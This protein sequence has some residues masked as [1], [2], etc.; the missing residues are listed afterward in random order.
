MGQGESRSIPIGGRKI[1]R[2]RQ[3]AE[4]AYGFVDLA[5]DKRTKE[6]FALKRVL[7]QDAETTRIAQLEI[8]VMT[9][10]HPHPHI[11]FLHGS[12]SRALDVD[13]PAHAQALRREYF[14][15]ME[16]CDRGTLAQAIAARQAAQRPYAEK[17]ALNILLAVCSA[18][19]HMHCQQ[20][21][22][23]HRDLKVC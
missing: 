20:P 14:M 8:D 9:R 6:P 2:Q 19:E 15:L 11:V 17:E 22:I 18:I 16:Y 12:A 23:V 13:A 7:A 4:G 21:P 1:V 10:L 3:L 5:I